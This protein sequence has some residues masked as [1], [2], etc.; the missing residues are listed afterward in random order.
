MLIQRQETV[1]E[2]TRMAHQINTNVLDSHKLTHT[3]LPRSFCSLEHF[4]LKWLGALCFTTHF[5]PQHT[6]PPDTLYFS[7]Q[8]LLLSTLC[9]QE[10]F[11]LQHILLHGTLRF[12]EHFVFCLPGSKGCCGEHFKKEQN[13]PGRKVFHGAEYYRKQNVLGSKVSKETKCSRDQNVLRSKIF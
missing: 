7:A 1:N 3:L 10:Y 13:V 11:S 8:I 9:S 5:A 2:L 4:T 6:L 12:L